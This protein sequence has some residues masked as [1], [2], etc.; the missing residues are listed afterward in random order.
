MFAWGAGSWFQTPAQQL[1]LISAAPHE[2]AVVVGL[3]RLGPL[4]GHRTRHGARRRPASSRPARRARRLRRTGRDQPRL[5]GSHPPLPLNFPAARTCRPG[6]RRSGQRLTLSC[7]SPGWAESARPGCRGAA[8][9]GISSS[10]SQSRAA[11]SG[12]HWAP[13]AGV[14]P[15]GAGHRHALA[16]PEGQRVNAGGSPVSS[17]GRTGRGACAR[18]FLRGRASA[19]LPWRIAGSLAAASP[20][21]VLVMVRTWRRTSRPGAVRGSN[22]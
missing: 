16:E 19:R 21:P 2:T 18:R 6:G 14:D 1:R 5:P 9:A 12:K 22:P 11:S 15:G 8:G 13:A 17:S 4:R 20:D 7:R 3:N 10:A